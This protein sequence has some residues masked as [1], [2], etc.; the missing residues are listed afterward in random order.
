MTIKLK[1][2]AP[3]TALRASRKT[4]DGGKEL[5][6]Q[7]VSYATSARYRE[8]PFWEELRQR[9][10]PTKFTTVPQMFARWQVL[11]GIRK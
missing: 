6:R 8:D 10:T 4:N 5:F 7:F 3:P 2:L 1:D 9:T 11:A